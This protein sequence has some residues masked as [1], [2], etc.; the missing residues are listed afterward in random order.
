MPIA[1]NE[2]KAIL[3][4]EKQD[5]LSSSQS[6]TL[7]TDRTKS[8][9]FYMGDMASDMPALPG[10]SQAVS[11]DVFDTVE[12]LMPDLMEIFAG[13]DEVVRFDPV[14]EDDVPAAEQETDYINH[15]FMQK[16]DGFVVLYD[17]IKDS[18]LSKN[19]IVKAW[20]EETE[21]ESEENYY[22]QPEEVLA[23][24]E[25]DPNVN[26]TELTPK[27]G[28]NE[29]AGAYTLFDV[30]VTKKQNY[31]CAKVMAV[32]PEEFGIARRARSIN[33]AHYCFHEVIVPAQELIDQGFTKA[34]V[35]KL[36][37]YVPVNLGDEESRSRDTVNESDDAPGGDESLN[38]AMR[39]I[40]KTEHYLKC[41]Y[42]KDGKTA[43]YRFVTAGEESIILDHKE[44]GK[45][46]KLDFMPFASMTPYRM[47]HRF[48][49]RS[50]YDCIK[51]I[52]LINTA[53]TRG[54][55]DNLY[56]ALNP[57]PYVSEEDS[58][59]STIDDLLESAPGKMVRGKRQG[60]VAYLLHPDVGQAAY[61]ML[62]FMASKLE[63]RTGV[64]RQGQGLNP[65]SLQNI[66]ENAVL[67]ASAAARARKRL[68]ARIFAETGIK[69]MFW[70]LHAITRKHAS[71]QEVVRLRNKWVTV[72]PRNWRERNDMTVDVG[73]GTGGKN[74]QMQG[75][76]TIITAQKEAVSLGMVSKRSFWNSAKELVKLAGR[77]DP[78]SFFIEP[79]DE[80]G[81]EPIEMD[82]EDP[83][84]QKAKMDAQIKAA[85]LQHKQQELQMEG[86]I[87]R[88]EAQFEAQLK[89]HEMQ[90]RQEIERL[91]AQADIATNQDKVGADIALA[92]EK[93]T[94]ERELRVME[95]QFKMN[96][97]QASLQ[98][99]MRT[100]EIAEEQAAR[101][102][103]RDE[104]A[105]T[106]EQKRKSA[107]AKAKSKP[108]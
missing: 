77:K 87:R 43:L 72:D 59:D 85:E 64:T 108:A 20:W 28:M 107:Q 46:V 95:H 2:L 9:D 42:K 83:A 26:I 101:Q 78:E 37:T 41:D 98:V 58:S 38:H 8:L 18:L 48:F 49:G 97:L 4:A 84:I 90:H 19:G 31:G 61:P 6:S 103:Q 96:E 91:Q 22:D 47:T 81:D 51:D 45:A 10:R 104:V 11:M 67:D 62:E 1:D 5:A 39:P 74:E 54:H 12:G 63:W 60:G 15:V 102:S 73:L 32:P 70:L 75:L 56:L 82:N 33:D 106:N 35:D 14:A 55:L 29:G 50:I 16:N 69:D 99:K 13:G 44:D 88:E 105:F 76:M 86:Q 65:D 53:L 66:G 27:E 24:F 71:Q 79:G 80:D 7:T 40:R 21:E 52:Q 92:R 89:E 68:V 17:F 93:F 3:S 100:A 25:A 94:L 30:T 34:T 57:R 23:Y 36:Q